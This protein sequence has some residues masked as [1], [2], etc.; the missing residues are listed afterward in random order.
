MGDS[1]CPQACT[2]WVNTCLQAALGTVVELPVASLPEVDVVDTAHHLARALQCAARAH[3]RPHHSLD[4]STDVWSIPGTLRL[5]LQE[6][7]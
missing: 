7:A 2:G 6:P 1:Q 4:S 3:A 5:A